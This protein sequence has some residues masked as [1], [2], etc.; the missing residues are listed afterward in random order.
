VSLEDGRT[1]DAALYATIRDEELAR[2]GGAGEGRLAEAAGL[3]DRLVLDDDF[4]EFL[5]LR[6]YPMLD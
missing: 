1:F 6:A 5:T 3:L 4:A 2:L